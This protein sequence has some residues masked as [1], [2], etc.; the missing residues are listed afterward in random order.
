[1]A[2]E[3]LLA[4]L[5]TMPASGKDLQTLLLEHGLVDPR[6]LERALQQHRSTGAPLWRVL[7][8]QE[9]I[10]AQQ[11]W[12]HL[13]RRQA[14]RRLQQ[15]ELRLLELLE[16]LGPVTAGMLA[17]LGGASAGSSGPLRRLIDSG[18]LSA[19]A[20]V[21]ALRPYEALNLVT[22][23][24]ERHL[25]PEVVFALP[26]SVI[27]QALVLPLEKQ[28]QVMTIGLVDPR[29]TERIPELEQRTGF[30]LRPVLISRADFEREVAR[31]AEP[32]QDAP[33]RDFREH[34]LASGGR[35]ALV[36][37][38]VGSAV[39]LT[40]SIIEGGLAARAADVHLEPQKG[41][42]RVRFR[43]DGR[44]YDVM[45]VPRPVEPE[46]LARIK[47]LAD[48]D[49]AEKRRPQDGHFSIAYG[50]KD[51]DLRVATLPTHT[52]EKLVLRILDESNVIRGIRHLGLDAEDAA[53]FEELIRRPNGMLLVTGPIGS[54]KTTTLYSAL[55]ALN[56]SEAN[57]VT[58]EDPVEYHL[59]GINQV[60]VDPDIGVTFASGLR[61]ILRQDAD[62]LMV[63]E[64]RDHETARVAAWAA[65]TGQ[66]VLCT[67]HTN[68][69]LAALGMMA[70]FAVER[71]VV[72][73]A[74]IGVVAQRLVRRLCPDC[75]EPYPVAPAVAAQLGLA[76]EPL[77]TFH[78]AKGCNF[79]YHTG[80]HGRTGIFELLVLSDALREKIVNGASEA[81]LRKAAAEEGMRTLKTNGL[82]K[83]LDGTTT[84]EEV[85]REIAV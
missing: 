72:A 23:D 17:D 60:Q 12:Q 53:R 5:D 76:D 83:V 36:A 65:M 81:E 48:M 34:L 45:T 55:G 13:S 11:L 63:G 50:G 33:R 73:G 15:A 25:G 47:I 51:Y 16:I 41:D 78:R 58:I 66:L 71:F 85:I 44:L 14:Q 7:V 80:F 19:E 59:Q 18:V 22:L 6:A 20:I 39:Q 64:I 61:A 35:S 10:P 67:L 54:G 68:E 8:A 57:I 69:A 40:K 62:V 3:D 56:T 52:G 43:I 4:A 37:P 84:L 9:A 26:V 74:V 46:V 28:G 29:G 21:E 2:D 42:M 32:G 49:I 82:K 70:N 75:R 30:V 27:R 79:C 77:L 24:S 1:M 31:L 38:G